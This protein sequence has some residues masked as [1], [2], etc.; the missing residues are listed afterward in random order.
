MTLIYF[1]LIISATVF[2]HELGHFIFAKKA[3][4]YVYEFAIGMGPKLYSF[5]RKNDETVYSIRLVPIGGFV[6]MAGEEIEEDKTIPPEKRMQSKTWLQRFFTIVAGCLFNFIFAIILFFM[7]GIIYGSYETKP[8]MASPEKGYPTQKVGIEKNDLILS[9]NGKVMN[10]TDDVAMQLELIPKGS[11]LILETKKE[12]GKII[13][14]KIAPK[15]TKEDG[16]IVYK[17]GISFTNRLNHGFIPAVKY[18]FVKFGSIFKTMFQIITNLITGNISIKSLAGPVGIYNIVGEQ[19]QN[20]LASILYLV[21]FLSINIGFVNLLPIP[22]FDGGRLLFL[23]IEK[24]KGSKVNPRVENI[25]HTIGFALLLLL[26][27]LITIQD[28]S[29]L[30]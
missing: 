17:Y 29:R 28:I 9:I 5:K 10:T 14:Y 13:T 7:I 23:F 18:A 2:V 26:M 19:A 21:A 4:I 11:T 30:L 8:Y 15:Q 20:G 22:A 12:T 6:Q 27:F 25:I 3:K 24:V 16:E 1:I